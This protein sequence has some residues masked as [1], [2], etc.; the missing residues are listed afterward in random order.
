[1]ELRKEQLIDKVLKE[2]IDWSEVDLEEIAL[3]THK[4]SIQLAEEDRIKREQGLRFTV[5]EVGESRYNGFN[6]DLPY[7]HSMEY[8]S[9]KYGSIGSNRTKEKS[10]LA[11]S[12]HFADSYYRL[13][14]RNGR[15]ITNESPMQF[16]KRRYSWQPDSQEKLFTKEKNLA[17]I[18]CL[19]YDEKSFIEN[20]IGGRKSSKFKTLQEVRNFIAAETGIDNF[21]LEEVAF[22][23]YKAFRVQVKTN[24]FAPALRPAGHYYRVTK[25]FNILFDHRESNWAESHF[26]EL[27]KENKQKIEEIHEKQIARQKQEEEELRIAEEKRQKRQQELE[28]R[29]AFRKWLD[30]FMEAHGEGLFNLFFWSAIIGSWLYFINN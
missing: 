18:S 29:S 22:A 27:M 5:F 11:S 8:Y 2:Q 15:V 9:M 23:E 7:R 3:E 10:R 12:H 25:Y 28:N 16:L 20:K 24:E 19:E 13:P 14:I 1:M 4:A 6:H 26:E 21:Q 30:D 17:W